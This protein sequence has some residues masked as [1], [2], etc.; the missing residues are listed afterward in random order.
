[1]SRRDLTRY[2]AERLS[3]AVRSTCLQK[4]FPAIERLSVDADEMAPVRLQS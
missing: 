1:M 3:E 4:D 2:A